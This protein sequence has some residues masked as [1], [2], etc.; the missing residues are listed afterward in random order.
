MTVCEIEF[1]NYANGAIYTGQLLRGTVRLIL[2][3]QKSVRGVY[4]QIC[5][6][7]FAEWTPKTQKTAV[8]AQT[9]HL[10]EKLYFVDGN[11]GNVYPVTYSINHF[12]SE[13]FKK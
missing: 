8:A 3:S 9:V 11:R 12:F 10:N 4:V 7:A 1:E 5:G 6:E 13:F 2:P